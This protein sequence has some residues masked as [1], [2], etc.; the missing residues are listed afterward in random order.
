[1]V[2]HPGRA[3]VQLAAAQLLGRHD[4]AGRGLHQRRAAE[5][6]RPLAAD[7]DRLVA[8]R[9][10]VGAAR[11]ARPHHRGDLRDAP[12]RHRGLVVEDAA[13]VLAVGEHLVLPGQ[14]RAAGV[15]QVDAGEPVVQRHLLRAQM[16]LHRDRVVRAALDRRVVGDDD[17]FAGGDPP[18]AGDDARARRL[19]PVH[20][21]RGQ[22]RQLQEGRAGIEERVDPVA[23]EQLPARDVPLAGP[24]RPAAPRPVDAVA[25]LRG[26]GLVVGGARLER[27]ARDVG[28]GAD[29]GSAHDPLPG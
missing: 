4:L 27:L 24:L 29:L 28:A 26:E 20:A 13:E 8:H 12:P 10:D 2:G 15:D 11:R 9:R 22:R 21:V 16:L 7:D 17:A 6:D 18:D 1:M 14:E 3:G 5:E 23:R 25:Q 19:V